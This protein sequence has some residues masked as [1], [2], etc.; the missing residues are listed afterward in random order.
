MGPIDRNIHQ[1]L[2]NLGYECAK[3]IEIGQGLIA[4]KYQEYNKTL[5]SI[6]DLES[7]I[8]KYRAND[9]SLDITHDVATKAL[10]QK[11]KNDGFH[12]DLKDVYSKDE[13]DQLLKSLHKD[14]SD[15]K[16][17]LENITKIDQLKIDSQ[18]ALMKM[19][20]KMIQ[21]IHDLLLH[22]CK[23]LSSH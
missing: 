8:N 16:T 13:V 1:H 20:M 6:K 14:L 4:D 22:I 17:N 7:S 11:A 12:I 21:Q 2:I 10:I 19:I 9:G 5:N 3:N 23:N 18:S 15:M